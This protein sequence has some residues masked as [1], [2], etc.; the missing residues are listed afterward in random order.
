MNHLN[1]FFLLKIGQWPLM[2]FLVKGLAYFYHCYVKT[3]CRNINFL[4]NCLFMLIV[5]SLRYFFKLVES[6]QKLDIKN[7]FEIEGIF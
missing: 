7:A 1:R 2:A 6:T 3:L 5:I 4:N